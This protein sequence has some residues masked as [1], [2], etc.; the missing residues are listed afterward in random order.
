MTQAKANKLKKKVFLRNYIW[1][2]I[3]TLYNI[4]KH[5]EFFGFL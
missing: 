3:R 1:L 5:G 4:E 2:I